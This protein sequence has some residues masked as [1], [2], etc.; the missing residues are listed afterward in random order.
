MER[1][2]MRKRPF[3]KARE[4][5]IQEE[6]AQESTTSQEKSQSS[7]HRKIP[8]QSENSSPLSSTE[9]TSHSSSYGAAPGKRWVRCAYFTKVRTVKGVAVAWQT[10]TSFAPVG[11][12]PQV[13]EA[14]LSEE[15]TIGSAPSLANTKSLV[16]NLEPWQEGPQTCT[17]KPTDQGEEHGER[18]RPTTPEWLV[19]RECGFRCVACCRVFESR[20]AL[21]AHA[22]HGVTQGFSCRVFFEELLERRLPRSVQRRPRRC[23][24]L[25]RRCLMAA[26]KREVREKTAVCRRLEEQ[27]EK[28][29]EELKRLRHQL[30]RLQRQETRLQKAQAHHR[31]QRGKRLKTC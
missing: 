21:V 3:S 9:Q 4:V 26:K 12:M 19:T 8:K 29:R 27:L 10:K 28:Q 2:Y 13:F 22:E 5:S 17:Q 18:P 31:G 6:N 25:A 15:S 24:Q 14:E 20:D 7:R 30:D 23:H 11:K 1:Q 16:S